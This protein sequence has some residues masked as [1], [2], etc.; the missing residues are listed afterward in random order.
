MPPFETRQ[1]LAGNVFVS[2]AIFFSNAGFEFI[3]LVFYPELFYRAQFP[4]FGKNKKKEILAIYKLCHFSRESFLE[5]KP[6]K[7]N[8]FAKE[9]SLF[10][11]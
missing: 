6:F 1:F 3:R 8:C 7:L 9:T 5:Q 4:K 10:I 11:K 2:K